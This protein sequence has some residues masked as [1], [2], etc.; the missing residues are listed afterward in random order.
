MH[1]KNLTVVLP[2]DDPIRSKT[3]FVLTSLFIRE[4]FFPLMT[5]VNFEY[6]FF[7]RCIHLF[8][9]FPG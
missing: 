9:E 6:R 4:P 3:C 8:F 1:K 2:Q 5:V 7:K